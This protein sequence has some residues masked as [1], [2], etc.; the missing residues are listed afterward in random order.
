MSR[1][2]LTP[3]SELS[4][5]G[6]LRSGIALL[7]A[8]GELRPGDALPAVR[9]L[10]RDLGVSVNTV[11]S[12]YARLETDGLVRTRQ[13]ATTTV[14]ASTPGSL[15][16]RLPR[17][18]SYAVGVL[19]AGLDP[20]YLPLLAGIEEVA[21]QHGLLVLLADTQDSSDRAAAMIRRLIARGVDGL[22]A[23]SVGGI[24]RADEVVPDRHAR[25]TLPPI[26]YV[27]QPERP[28]HSL[29]FDAE[30][31]GYLATRHLVD[32]GHERVAMLTAP[33]DLANMGILHD[34]Y[35]RAL[36]EAAKPQSEG[37]MIEVAGFDL[38]AGRAGLVRLLESSN[39]PTAVFAAGAD[40][41]LG[42]IDQARLH[43]VRVPD[44]L[45]V[46]GY[47]DIPTARLVEPPL[48]MVSV[49]AREIGLRAMTTL[50]RLMGGMDVI[51][52]R[53][54]LE[55]DLTVRESCGPH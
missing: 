35:R 31:G 1:L 7:I 32:H 29:V 30:R 44:D 24:D 14:V 9:T 17:L 47:A 49:P 41:A 26:V 43:G 3:G 20:F 19:I 2:H 28:G 48:T 37:I 39:R 12:A 45:A 55:V 38:D 6:Q 50:Q 36:S 27:D 53:V 54:V 46:V 22:I 15:S 10:A 23:I 34:G 40:L 11:R 8:D 18:G 51:P 25:R 52:E 16:G 21:A 42:V 4:L 5:A 33:L 13:G